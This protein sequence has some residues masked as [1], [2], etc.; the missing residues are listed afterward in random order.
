MP[1]P[2]STSPIYLDESRALIVIKCR[3]HDWYAACR[4]HRDE[5]YDAACAHE[6][7]EHV[8]DVRQRDARDKR[9]RVA[10]AHPRLSSVAGERV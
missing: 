5:A 9:R 6:A 8:G 3:D 7:A 4:F 1:G 2:A 10:S